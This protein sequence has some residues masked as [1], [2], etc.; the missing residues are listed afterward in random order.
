MQTLVIPQPNADK[1]IRKLRVKKQMRLRARKANQQVA[2][3]AK[4]PPDVPKT[5]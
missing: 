5:I 2:A 4:K 3:L 1:L